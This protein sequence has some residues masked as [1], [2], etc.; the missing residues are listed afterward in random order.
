MYKGG[1]LRIGSDFFLSFAIDL[2]KL[3]GCEGHALEGTV[4]GL[5]DGA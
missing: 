4:F 2:G 5:V 1:D 3:L